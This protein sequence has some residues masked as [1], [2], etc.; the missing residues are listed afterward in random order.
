[1][2]SMPTNT[3]PTYHQETGSTYHVK[4]KRLSLKGGADIRDDQGQPECFIRGEAAWIGQS[5]HLIDPSGILL[6]RF[7]KKSAGLSQIVHIYHSNEIVAVIRHLPLGNL[8]TIDIL[9]GENLR[10]VAG[11][12]TFEYRIFRLEEQI[13]YISRK[14]L[15]LGDDY[16][17]HVNPV[18]QQSLMLSIA[19]ALTVFNHDSHLGGEELSKQKRSLQSDPMVG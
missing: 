5:F 18:E 6:Y 15:C 17:V 1:M 14:K 9:E 10:A 16:V 2:L 8:V 12:K 19:I 11:V 13:A 7:H 3:P 4:F